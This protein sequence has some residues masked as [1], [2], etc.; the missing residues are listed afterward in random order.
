[1]LD[2]KIF[3]IFVL[4]FGILVLIYY[5]NGDNSISSITK[6]QMPWGK[7]ELFHQQENSNSVIP[8]NAT[9]ISEEYKWII[10]R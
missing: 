8:K 3:I 6:T 5:S 10:V 1:M 4:C 9:Q 7:F 2:K